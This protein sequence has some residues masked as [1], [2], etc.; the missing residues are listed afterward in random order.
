ML[1]AE[2]CPIRGSDSH[3]PLLQLT[4]PVTCNN[5]RG[6]FLVANSTV[7]C[8]C[9][10]C[11]YQGSSLL[12]PLSPAEFERHSGLASPKRWQSSIHLGV[13]SL[14]SIGHWLEEHGRMEHMRWDSSPPA[15]PPCLAPEVLDAPVL[16]DLNGLDAGQVRSSTRPLPGRVAEENA[17]HGV[18]VSEQ[19]TA[20]SRA[21][22]Q[23]EEEEMEGVEE[24]E[25]LRVRVEEGRVSHPGRQA[26][27]AGHGLGG[28]GPRQGGASE[29]QEQGGRAAALD[30]VPGDPPAPEPE[31]DSDTERSG[32]G[33]AGVWGV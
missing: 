28:A 2:G 26:K 19:C 20:R 15:L 29:D 8:G 32:G 17:V 1:S 7:L 16:C 12:N 22:E 11:A 27:A 18:R 3:Q 9:A 5:N 24:V 30:H 10:G 14:V 23:P 4:L 6:V 33:E 21:P 13:G 25:V 31:Y